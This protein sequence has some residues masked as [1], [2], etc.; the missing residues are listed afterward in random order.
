[1]RA[2][3]ILLTNERGGGARV[4][5]LTGLTRSHAIN[6]KQRYLKEGITALTDKRKG[7]P[8]ELLTKRQRE[9]ILKTLK[10]KT[11]KDLGYAHEHWSSSILG[12]WIEKTCKVKYKSKTSLY[13]IFRKVSFTY[14]RPGTKYDERND[15]EVAAW[16]K[17]ATRKL[18][19]LMKEK[20]T[21]I[22]TGDEMVLT[23]ATTIQKVWLPVGEYPKVEVRTGTR[24]R[25]HVYGF[26]N[27]RTGNEHAWKTEYQTMYVTKDILKSIRA[28]Y[29]KKKI[30]LFWDNAGWHKG[31]VVR[32]F[33]KE[34]GNIEIV[35]FP[36]YA[37]DENPQE[38][39]WKAGRSAV[40]HNEYISDIDT[41]TD[42]L[43]KFF[44]NTTFEYSFLG[45][46]RIS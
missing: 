19:A 35:W 43:V 21:V 41:A 34:D 37:P 5:P 26:L 42:A 40:T 22:L 13:L 44:N 36:R 24:L 2:Q 18:N 12:D 33:L 14:H 23:T 39:V 7:K 10:E 31:S 30:A 28:L 15:E 4:P 25:R 17:T 29:P 46:S 1:L 3:A 11:P 45:K 20:D 6:I 9:A 27:L 8:K 38:K 16:Q 32:D